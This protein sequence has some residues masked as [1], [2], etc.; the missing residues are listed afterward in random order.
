MCAQSVPTSR[1]S[2]SPVPRISRR[3]RRR[4][5]RVTS[6]GAD[7]KISSPAVLRVLLAADVANMHT[8]W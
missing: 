8:F 6:V 7:V 1:V 3:L 4:R 2:D 5:D